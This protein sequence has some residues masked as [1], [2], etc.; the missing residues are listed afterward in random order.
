MDINPILA[1]LGENF[2]SKLSAGEI[3]TKFKVD[4]FHF[5]RAFN[6]I[7]RTTF[8]FYIQQLRLTEARKLIDQDKSLKEA[9]YSAGFQSESQFYR[10]FKQKTGLT[11]KEYRDSHC[12]DKK[13]IRVE[14]DELLIKYI[15]KIKSGHVGWGMSFITWLEIN[16]HYLLAD[17]NKFKKL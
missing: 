11:P 16:N 1:Y 7:T 12:F 8:Q 10:V 3:A 9:C 15:E 14:L 6:K 17:Y 2:R 4:R 13:D 5:S